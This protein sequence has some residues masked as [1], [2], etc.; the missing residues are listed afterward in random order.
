[1]A[2][3]PLAIIGASYLQEPLIQKAKSL[4]YET[5]V[6]AWEAGDIGE[7]S[8]DVFHPIS[9]TEINEIIEVCKNVNVCGVCTIATD[10]GNHTASAV[11]NALGLPT[12][13]M[14]AVERSTNKALMR[15]CFLK[16]NDPSPK[17][18]VCTDINSITTA[19][20]SLP[21]IVK[22]VDRSGSRGITKVNSKNQLEDAVRSA[23]DASFNKQCVIEEYIDGDEFSVE[24]ISSQG[25]HT[26]LALTKKFTTGAPHFIETGHV[27]PA[28]IN[29]K[30][31]ERI[32]VI[33][34]HAL[35]S[36]GIIQGASH[37]EIRITN[38]DRI[39]LI[40]IGSRMGGDLIGSHLV[41]L[42]TGYDFLKGVIDCA[43]GKTVDPTSL[44]S[45][46]SNKQKCV[47]VRFIFDKDD[48]DAYEHASSDKACT[49]EFAD[50]PSVDS[51]DSSAVKDSS[52]R[53]GCFLLSA[54]SREDLLPYF[55]PENEN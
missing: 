30:T 51:L 55:P 42:S 21:L 29:P 49:V 28:D 22:P 43:V 14:D 31:L 10:L 6:F 19:G 32:K 39:Y 17:S 35:D 40:E 11:A 7:K 12:N 9:I 25:Q 34:A 37:S 16:Q 54:D 3:Q 36:L 48:L 23:L 33:V 20:M 41:E 1:M 4:G 24:F 27:E 45:L 53:F 18:I 2:K 8:A 26:F 50:I 47:L 38:D 5:H 46:L 44:E 52:S 15:A 13:P